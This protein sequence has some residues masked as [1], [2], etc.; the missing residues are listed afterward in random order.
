MNPMAKR[1]APRP[2][3]LI[4]SH[5]G[6]KNASKGDHLHVRGRTGVHSSIPGDMS[7]EAQ[8]VADQVMAL[9]HV[10]AAD[11]LA[12]EEVGRIVHRIAQMDAELDRRMSGGPRRTALCSIYACAP[13]TAWS[14]GAASSA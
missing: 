5:P 8:M 1:P 7:F 6:N 14:A 2:E 4:P 11:R 9:A 10:S 12:A 13:R 3:N